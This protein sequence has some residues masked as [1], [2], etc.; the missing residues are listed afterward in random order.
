M[1]GRSERRSVGGGTPGNTDEWEA[2]EEG[3][4]ANERQE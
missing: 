4:R 1:R 2:E 3:V